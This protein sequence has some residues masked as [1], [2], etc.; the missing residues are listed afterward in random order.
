[1]LGTELAV[2]GT[3]GLASSHLVGNQRG[4]QLFR[5]NQR[6]LHIAVGVALQEQLLLNALGQDGKD[7]HGFLAQTLF[8]ESVLLFPGGERIEGSGLFTG[9]QLVDL[10]NQH[11]ELGNKFHDALGDDGNTEIH[12][13]G[14]SCGHGVGDDIG[15]SGKGHLLGG[16]LFA[17][18][19]DVGL[20]FKSAFQSNMGGG[21]T[22]HLDEMPVFLCG[23]AVAL[24]VADE[25]AVGLGSGIEAEGALNVFVLQVAVDGLGAANDLNAGVVGRAVLCQDGSVGVGVVAADDDQGVDTVLLAVF[26]NNGELLLGLQLGTAGTNDVEAAGVAVLVDVLV[27]EDDEVIIQQAGGTAFEAIQL[28]FLVG[29]LQGIVQAAD[30]VVT[31]RCLTTGKNDTNHQLTSLGSV[32]TLFKD[33][34]VLAVGI[35]EQSLDLLLVSD[36]L[37][38]TAVADGNLRNTVSE[39]TG[40]FGNVLVSCSLQRGQVHM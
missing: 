33:D 8:D 32:L 35:G 21:T 39:H 11:G 37:S 9:Q 34:L 12:A 30:N 2:K 13:L 4:E 7:G 22:H 24:D 10:G 16:N 40:Q 14:G 19:A 25:L 20:G 17:N 29:S 6:D 28:V 15:N 26:H 38:S 27:T 31:A 18:Q 5:L 36:R 3:G 23:V 1:M